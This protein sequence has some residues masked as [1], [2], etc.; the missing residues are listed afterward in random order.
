MVEI[1]IEINI[2]WVR[3]LNTLAEKSKNVNV[4]EHRTDNQQY[5]LHDTMRK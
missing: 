2:I 4:R 5:L 1:L 3:K